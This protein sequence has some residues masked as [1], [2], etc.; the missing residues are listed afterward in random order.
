VAQH[1]DGDDALLDDELVE[2]GEHEDGGLAHARLGLAQHVH[3]QQRVRDGLVL[4]CTRRK[5]GP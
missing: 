5:Q 3:A 4:H 2:R 1:E